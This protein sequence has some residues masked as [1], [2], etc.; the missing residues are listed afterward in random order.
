[1][2]KKITDLDLM[3]SAD[4]TDKLEI[5][6]VSTNTNKQVAVGGLAAAVT[7]NTPDGTITPAMRSGGFHVV[8]YTVPASTGSASITD[9]PFRPK[10]FLVFLRAAGAG[11]V[12]AMIG[13]YDGTSV[14]S[15]S[16]TVGNAP[17]YANTSSTTQILRTV[18]SN[19]NIMVE[20]TVTSINDDGI[21]LNFATTTTSA[22]YKDY[23][24]MFFG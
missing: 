10:G 14:G 19:G 21:T 17:G 24:F 15:S 2:P 22:S 6:D 18:A 23:T 13:A 4:D 9:V 5:V 12:P 8:N 7:A 11:T 16:G 20:A 1:M 3:E